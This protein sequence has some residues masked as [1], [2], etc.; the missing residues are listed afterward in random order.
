[1]RMVKVCAGFLTMLSPTAMAV[2][3]HSGLSI[4][5]IIAGGQALSMAL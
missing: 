2:E 1:M 4:E 5:S 3:T